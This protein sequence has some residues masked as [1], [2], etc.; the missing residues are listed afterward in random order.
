MAVNTLDN[1]WI[2]DVFQFSHEQYGAYC[3][4]IVLPPE[5]YNALTADQLA[6][7]KQARFDN[8]VAHITDASNA[9]PD[10]AA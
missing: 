6:A 9:V 4:A 8:W 7:M 3:D 1:G 2:Q 5:E 10:G